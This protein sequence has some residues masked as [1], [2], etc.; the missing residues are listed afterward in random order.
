MY[1]GEADGANSPIAS[2]EYYHDVVNTLGQAKTDEFMRY[3]LIPGVGHCYVGDGPD[4]FNML[5]TLQNWVEKGEA[6]KPIIAAQ[7][8]KDGKPVRTRPLCP[9]PQVSRYNGSGDIN[10]A[11]NFS[12]VA[13]A[14]KS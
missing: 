13:P 3:Y 14:G 4:V 9:F 6:P 7:F 12:C 1:H 5:P 8:G 10:D 2:T 11:A